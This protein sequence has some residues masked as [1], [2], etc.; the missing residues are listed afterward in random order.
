MKQPQESTGPIRPSKKA[1]KRSSVKELV[2]VFL[3]AG[4]SID[5]IVIDRGP[6]GSVSVYK[7]VAAIAKPKGKYTDWDNAASFT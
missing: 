2:G 1:Q 4:V 5:D 7:R 3:S 6:D